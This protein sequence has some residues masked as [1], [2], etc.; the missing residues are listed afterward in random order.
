VNPTGIV[1]A[2][3]F[4]ALGVGYALWVRRRM[5]APPPEGTHPFDAADMVRFL[6]TARVDG[7]TA[8]WPRGELVADRSALLVRAP[9]SRG[10]HNDLLVARREVRAIRV[11]GSVLARRV[12]ITATGGARGR[13]DETRFGAAFS[14]PAPGLA[15]LGWPVET[16][17]R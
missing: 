17:G 7:R 5:T 8:G 9:G 11:E 2:V 14:D 6:G 13:A 16:P 4:V 10:A 1:G 3:A 12:V 15:R